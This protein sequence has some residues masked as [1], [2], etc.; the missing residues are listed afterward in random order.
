MNV[1][2]N[3]AR[4]LFVPLLVL[5]ALLA[6]YTRSSHVV[7]AVESGALDQLLQPAQ[8][9]AEDSKPA[10]SSPEAVAAAKD[11]AEEKPAEQPL[12]DED[13]Q[14]L[15]QLAARRAEL[16][17]R[18]AAIEQREALL[19]A[20]EQKVEAKIAE[21]QTMRADLE[22][23][24]AQGNKERTE[25]LKSLVKIYENMKPKQAAAIFEQLDLK[26]LL[27]VV[28][29]MKEAKAAPV[30]AAMNPTKAKVVT[31]EL[32]KRKDLQ[33]AGASPAPVPAAALAPPPAPDAIPATN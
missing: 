11:K 4:I 5:V 6:M 2:Q 31:T 32:M 20:A 27:T 28:E 1:L 8:A 33:K 21:L 19:Q 22:K 7:A 29:E 17:K 3:I 9:I 26:I 13:V 12:T 15:Q 30:L 25:Q 10:P 23:L 18:A 24:L 14:I 16:D